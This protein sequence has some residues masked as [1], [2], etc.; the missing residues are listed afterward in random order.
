MRRTELAHILRAACGVTND[1]RI[2]VIGSQAILATFDEDA[3]PQEA[4]LSIEAD[5]AFFDDPEERKSD[6]VD[7]A[8]GEL[9][10]F[11]DEFGI[12]GQGVSLSTATLPTGW[13]ERLTSFD[14]PE[15]G[16]SQAVCLEPHD[17]VVSKLVAG[18]EK[19][20]RF[21]RAL[22]DAGLI[23]AEVLSARTELLPG[24]EAVRRRVLAWID[25]AGKRASGGRR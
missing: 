8:I 9:S 13:E 21:A 10:V 1:S 5:I 3:L 12:Y 4:T 11:H 2:L 14:D 18:R 19:D 16:E 6:L 15:A 17:L 24:P 7:G 20:Y 23:R 25:S 22:L